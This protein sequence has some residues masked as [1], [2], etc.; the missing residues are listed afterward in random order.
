MKFD[1]IT[2]PDEIYRRS[3]EIIEAESDLSQVP[4]DIKPAVV[5]MVHAVGDPSIARDIAFSSD[6]AVA[7][8]AALNAGATI[9]TDVEMVGNGIRNNFV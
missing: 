6:A 3:F 2:D 5:R 4:A 8:K 1:F 9:F 7:A